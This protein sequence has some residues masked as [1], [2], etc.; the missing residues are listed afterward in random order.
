MRTG[1]KPS[2]I[3]GC[4]VGALYLYSGGQIL[5]LNDPRGV[6]GAVGASAILFL[7]SLPRVAKGPVPAGLTVLSAAVGAYYFQA[8]R[9]LQATP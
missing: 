5:S 1:S 9:T 8:V 6:Y 4:T 2:L 7:S 3:A